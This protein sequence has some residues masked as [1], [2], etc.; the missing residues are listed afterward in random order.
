M[1]ECQFYSE[2][3][4]QLQAIGSARRDRLSEGA[5][6]PPTLLRIVIP[7]GIVLLLALEYRPKMPLAGQLVHMGMLAVVV[8][9]CYLLVIV[10]GHPFSGDVA[11]G[12]DPLRRGALAE[13]WASDEPRVS[14]TDAAPCSRSQADTPGR[15]GS[16]NPEREQRAR[17]AP[18]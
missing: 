7:L 8:S 15:P 4:G 12:N 2:A 9:F 14:V 18:G 1:I 3:V 17:S 13:F 6:A 16:G 5:A 11:V 10:M